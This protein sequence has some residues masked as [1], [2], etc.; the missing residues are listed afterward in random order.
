MRLV[1]KILPAIAFAMICTA[2]LYAQIGQGSIHGKV[3]NTDGK[4]LQNAQVVVESITRR[5]N[6][7]TVNSQDQTKT[8]RNGEYSISGLYNGQY[9]VTIMVDGKAVMVRG[10]KTGDDLYVA[11]G[12]DVSVNFNLKD[13]PATAPPTPA[14][15]PAA[16]AAGAAG[17]APP[18]DTKAAEADRKNAAETK[19]AF[20]AGKAAMASNN[21][22]EAI[23]QFSL[24]AE[25]DPKQ[26]VIFGNLGVAYSSAKKY[27]DSANAYRKAIELKPDEPPY[28]AN[29]SLALANSG[30]FDEANEAVAK[31]AALDP[32]MAGQSYYNLGAI[33]TNRGKSKE[34]VEAFKK[35]I[36]VDPQNANAFYQLGIAYFGAPDTI[37]Q[38]VPA[39][40]NYLK[41]QPT[42]PNAE[43]AKQLIEAAKQ[44]SP[45]AFKSD[46][47][48]AAEKKAE[49]DKQKAAKTKGK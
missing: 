6:A 15:A 23:K 38:A 29:L 39:L 5:G 20:D 21:F 31:A 7:L 18:R 35:S 34:A 49:Q 14:A 2:M 12:L 41:L 19:T 45:A 28:F 1:F 42:G 10:D 3:L 32:K 4:G 43:A 26:H 27:E 46:R 47:A 22:D 13:A 9:R 17:A 8:N 25:K 48:V 44:Q 33:L 40:E 30:K 24:A 37:P 16:G 11:N 36:E